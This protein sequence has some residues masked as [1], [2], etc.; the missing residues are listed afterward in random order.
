MNNE[1]PL[2]KDMWKD[3]KYM[4]ST[5]FYGFFFV[6]SIIIA[7]SWTVPARSEIYEHLEGLF[8]FH[9]LYRI[10]LILLGLVAAAL[11]HLYRNRER[12][13]LEQIPIIYK[14]M[15]Q[16][17][18]GE[19]INSPHPTL[20]KCWGRFLEFQASML[21]FSGGSKNYKVKDLDTDFFRRCLQR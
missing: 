8:Y 12:R 11:L 19:S 13:M 5:T 7:L 4:L 21:K 16:M 1:Q 20:N 10:P 9:P 2:T 6:Y 14:Q 3:I 18:K 17:E 15:E